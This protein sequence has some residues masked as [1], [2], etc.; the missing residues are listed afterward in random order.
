MIPT[1]VP[2]PGPDA[3]CRRPALSLESQSSGCSVREELIRAFQAKALV[4]ICNCCATVP[5]GLLVCL[6]ATMEHMTCTKA[7]R[8]QR[9]PNPTHQ[10]R[11]VSSV[12]VSRLRIWC[13]VIY[14]HICSCLFACTYGFLLALL[15]VG[16]ECGE[17]FGI[18][19]YV[20]HMCC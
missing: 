6:V 18:V 11:C 1:Y 17:Q 9:K 10:N 19:R 4:C 15:G 12:C 13:T 16:F 7:K 2:A 3:L 5:T 14:N 8:V 20:L